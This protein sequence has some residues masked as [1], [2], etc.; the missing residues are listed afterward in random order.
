[1]IRAN[2]FENR[3]STVNQH[4]RNVM[5][6]RLTVNDISIE[7]PLLEPFARCQIQGFN[8]VDEYL[9][10]EQ[11]QGTIISYGDPFGA[12]ATAYSGQIIACVNDSVLATR[13]YRTI[14]KANDRDPARVI[15]I[16]EQLDF[17]ADVAVIHVP[18][19]APLLDLYIDAAI[20]QGCMHFYFGVM[21]KH[22]HDG[23]YMHLKRRFANV[24]S[25]PIRKKARLVRCTEPKIVE[26]IDPMIQY[27]YKDQPVISHSALFS[28]DDIDPGSRFLLESIELP[29]S[30]KRIL[31]TGCGNGILAISLAGPESHLVL[32]DDSKIAVDVAAKNATGRGLSFEAIH[33]FSVPEMDPVD[34]V[35]MNPP[36]HLNHYVC[37]DLALQ[38]IRQSARQLRPGGAAVM[39]QNKRFANLK[40]LSRYFDD[41]SVLADS[42]SYVVYVGQK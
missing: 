1:M 14:C 26:P 35:V 42:R 22:M 37:P 24:E 13:S 39:V 20:R 30:P 17:S 41:I 4:G 10:S 34:M 6:S 25:L 16:R 15:S 5:Q 12:T 21:I 29:E 28:R 36:F 32:M 23:F 3:F 38:L 9:I 18:K 11:I 2:R 27:R 8:A 19:A 33:D 7:I 40:S 31:D